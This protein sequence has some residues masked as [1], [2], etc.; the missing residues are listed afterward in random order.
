MHARE[1]TAMSR[2][3]RLAAGSLSVALIGVCYLRPEG[4]ELRALDRRPRPRADPNQHNPADL[5]ILLL[6]GG[7]GGRGG[8]HIAYPKG[9]PFTNLLVTLIE[10]FGVPLE[11]LGGSTG[12]V[13][14]PSLSL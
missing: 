10:R 4:A 5:P 8:R 14:L 2:W 6:G 1:G 12:K 13:D 3:W 7:V 11:R 9:T